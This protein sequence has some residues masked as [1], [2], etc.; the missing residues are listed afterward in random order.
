MSNVYKWA[1]ISRNP[2]PVRFNL[3]SEFLNEKGFKNEFTAIEVSPPDFEQV[4]NDSLKKYKALRF[5]SPFGINC[6][7]F[8]NYQPAKI[9]QLRAADSVIN[10]NGQW[11]LMATTLKGFEKHIL[12]NGKNIDLDYSV[13]IVGTG[14]AS[15]FAIHALLQLGISHV[16]ISNQFREQAKE[17][18]LELEKKYFRVKFEY[19]PDDQLVLLPGTNSVLVNTTPLIES[20]HILNELYYFNF[21]RANGLVI[22]YTFLPVKTPLIEG[23][24]QIGIHTIHGYEVCAWG[25]LHWAKCMSGLDLDYKEYCQKIFEAGKKWDE[26]NKIKETT[27]ETPRF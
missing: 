16:K 8:F 11:E 9:A 12:A 17:L 6:L 13:L 3:L 20:N 10:I 19:V 21:L 24:E 22:D 14:S 4:L 18:I 27:K 23:A 26:Q 5:G 25:D 1:E 15:K 2:T 7:D